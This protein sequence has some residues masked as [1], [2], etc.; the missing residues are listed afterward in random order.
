MSGASGFPSIINGRSLESPVMNA[1][2]FASWACVFRYGQK[3]AQV[4]VAHL[5]DAPEPRFAAGRVLARRQAEEGSELAPA[6]EGA[7]VLDRGHDRRCGDRADA[8]NG[9]QPLGG[10]VRL[11][12]RGDLPVERSYRL[13]E[14]VDLADE[15]T[16]RHADAIGGDDLAILVETVAS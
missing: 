16:K 7:G 14:R 9:H 6:G 2:G 1:D 3:L 15:R 5:G 8:G 13:V 4:A 12:R 10:R 11:D